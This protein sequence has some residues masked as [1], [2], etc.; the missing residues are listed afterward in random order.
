M[1]ECLAIPKLVGSLTKSMV[2]SK[3]D[4]SLANSTAGEG[5]QNKHTSNYMSPRFSAKK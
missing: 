2:I 4:T 5:N 1:G 3:E